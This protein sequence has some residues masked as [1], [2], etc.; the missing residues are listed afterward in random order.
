LL[1]LAV[2]ASPALAG[3]R[4]VTLTH[5]TLFKAGFVTMMRAHE[6]NVIDTTGVAD[7]LVAV[8]THIRVEVSQ[9][10]D[11]AASYTL[12]RDEAE[13]LLF[14][15]DDE[16]NDYK[17][18]LSVSGLDENTRETLIQRITLLTQLSADLRREIH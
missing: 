14:V 15:V 9:Q 4:N 6:F 16:E 2:V 13:W 17:N 3:R 11:T 8:A 12:P 18:I 10:G 1:L 7:S 5:E